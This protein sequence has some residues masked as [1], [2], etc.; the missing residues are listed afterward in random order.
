MDTPDSPQD[1]DLVEA[2]PSPL[3]HLVTPL[4]AVAV[5]MVVRKLVNSAYEKGTGHTPPLPRD[6]NVSLWRAIA[7]TA[8]ITTTAAAAEV[9]VY[10]AMNRI[11]STSA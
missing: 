4:V 6:P 5:T 1:V 10:R 9:I 3:V 2:T 8:V 11:G 7:W